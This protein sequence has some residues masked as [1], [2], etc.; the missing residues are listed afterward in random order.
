[1]NYLHIY[2]PQGWQRYWWEWCFSQSLVSWRKE[3]AGTLLEWASLLK[4]RCPW[5]CIS[6]SSGEGVCPNFIPSY[7]VADMW[8][9]YVSQGP[10]SSSL[11]L[12][13]HVYNSLCAPF[14][15]GAA[16]V[17]WGSLLHPS[18]SSFAALWTAF[19]E[20]SVIGTSQAA[21]FHQPCY[22]PHVVGS[23]SPQ[24][25]SWAPP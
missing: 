12:Y 17:Q 13:K 7:P 6:F 24:V 18:S 3:S 25:G 14:E 20:A 5:Q 15:L 8:G 9:Q 16:L 4:Q 1:M 11:V 19:P 2:W 21:K 23:S 22:S 10:L